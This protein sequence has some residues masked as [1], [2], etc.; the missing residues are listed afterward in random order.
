VS[1]A[2]LLLVALVADDATVLR[3]SPDDVA[4]AQATLYRGDWLEV[5]GEAAGFLRVYDHR[6][7]RPGYV[8][9]TSVRSYHADVSVADELRAVVTFLRDS[10]G[11][12]S[13]GIGYAALWLRVA[14]PA[15][16]NSA[17]GADLF[18]ALG[19]MAERL[20]RQASARGARPGDATLAGHIAVAESYG[21]RFTTVD[22]GER[23]RSCY[24]GD[25]FVRVLA[26]SAV[27]T[28][29]AARAAL[30]LS[31][32]ACL[33]PRTGPVERRAWNEARLRILAEVDPSASARAATLP[34]FLAH[35]VRLRMAE[36]FTLRAHDEARQGHGEAATAAAAAALRA[37]ALVD[38]GQLAPEDRPLY[39]EA[40]LRVAANRWA[41]QPAPRPPGRRPE[42]VLA[43]GQPGE[44]CVRLVDSGKTLIERCT[45]GLVWRASMRWAPNGR[46]L[47]LAVQAL[48]A[49][50]ELW[51]FEAPR[52]DASWRITSLSPAAG[53]PGQDIGYVE[54]AGFSPDGARVLVAREA[55]VGGRFVRRFEVMTAGSLRVER[56]ASDA[57][58]LLAF[59]RWAAP[60]W[61]A[62]TLALR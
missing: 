38:R 25:A 20:A 28:E 42:V 11:S 52:E 48:P 51:L 14:S 19:A 1:P 4:A 39:E 34:A 62:E 3:N 8:R 30:S 49:W 2:A 50:T 10:S 21:V 32:P 15:Q 60:S 17:E 13:L 22:D 6:H 9:R 23:S 26:I 46:A 29:T 5:R 36:A 58:L 7:E 41:M 45:Y 43:A 57:G 27:R 35:R 33:D 37:L 53:S 56:S 18:Q 16:L 55:R 12:E 59:K 54:S 40:A 44:T 61:R 24:D 47:A 31:E